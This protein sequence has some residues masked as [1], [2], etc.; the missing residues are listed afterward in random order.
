MELAGRGLTSWSTWCWTAWLKVKCVF[1]VCVCVFTEVVQQFTVFCRNW[2]QCF[3]PTGV[4]EIDIAATLE[5]VRDQRPGMVRTKVVG[6]TSSCYLLAVKF[7]GPLE[8]WQLWQLFFVISLL[9]GIFTLDS[10][11]PKKLIAGL[12][13][14]CF[15]LSNCG[16]LLSPGPVWV[17]LDSRCRGGQRHPQGSA[18]VK[19]GST[20]TGPDHQARQLWLLHLLSCRFFSLTMM[21]IDMFQILPGTFSLPVT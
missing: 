8:C 19:P 16:L 21:I 7:V 9:L 6:A 11:L 13:F 18:P 12:P 4:K 3:V 15:W 5:H 14:C 2:T 17:C 1:W 20:C 10:N